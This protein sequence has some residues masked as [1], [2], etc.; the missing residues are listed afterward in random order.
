MSVINSLKKY[1][2]DSDYRFR[3]N[4][5]KG[6]YKS[7]PDDEYLKRQFK[8]F[9]GKKLDLENP[10]TFNEKLQW[11]KLYDRRPEYT[12]MVDKYEVKGYVSQKIGQQYVIPLIGVWEDV[13][14]IDFDTLPQQFVLKCTHD[15]HGLV[16]C[17]NKDELN[18][19]KAK[20]D[21]RS[22]LKNDYYYR[23]REWPYKNVKPRIIAE[24]YMSNEGHDLIDYKVHCFNGVPKI[25]LV[26]DGR[27]SEG[28]LTEDFYDTSWEHLPVSR[29]LHPNAKHTT[30]KPKQLEKM[31]ELSAIMSSDIPFLRVDF[32][33]IHGELFFGELTFFPASGFQSFDPSDFDNELGSWITLPKKEKEE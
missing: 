11:L 14:D 16:I 26:C 2:T 32:Y 28:G 18:I 3:F 17:K 25:I 24:K 9:H 4:A 15:S 1:F 23:F 33:I 5:S 10:E 8:A 7:M 27:F 22:A 30:E 29:P 13:D 19:N 31:L 20:K 12:L 6:C 21:L